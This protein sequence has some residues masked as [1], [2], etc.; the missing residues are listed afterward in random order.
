MKEHGNMKQECMQVFVCV[1]HTSF[2]I[3]PSSRAQHPA[4]NTRQL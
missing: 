4:P 1:S 2:T 3:H